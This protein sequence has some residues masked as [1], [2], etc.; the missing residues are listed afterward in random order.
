MRRSLDAE[1]LADVAADLGEGPAWD[2]ERGVLSWVDILAGRVHVSS[3][4]GEVLRTHT[5]GRAVGA[6]LPAGD[7]GFLLADADGFETLCE[8]G[9]ASALLAVIADRPELRFNDGKC[10]PRGRAWAGT[11]HNDCAPGAGKLYRLDAG[12]VV[13]PVLS[14]LTVSNGL[15]WSPD[16]GTMWF[17]DSAKRQV[18]AFDYD[19]ETGGLGALRRVTE[20]QQT[21]ASPDGLCVDDDGCIWLALWGG[22]AVHRYTPG[23]CLDTVVRV[24][25]DHVTSCCFGGRG[26]S[27]LFIT[28]ARRG[29]FTAEPGVTGPAAVP[30]RGV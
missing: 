3:A 15:G 27:T 2:A 4:S 1:L 6:A 16:G 29:L 9:D 23:G 14:G 10:D 12:P 17:A 8:E 13:T 28:T 22:G 11:M 25:A 26:Q 20:L 18:S 30:W 7:G 19:I 24:P 5:H 21:A